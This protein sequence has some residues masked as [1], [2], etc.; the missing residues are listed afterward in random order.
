MYAVQAASSLPVFLVERPRNGRPRT[1]EGERVGGS[2]EKEGEETAKT[3]EK[4]NNNKD[5]GRSEE[6]AP[7]C[8]FFKRKRSFFSVC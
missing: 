8:V 1:E 2:E 4:T 7:I 5:F 3:E 6:K